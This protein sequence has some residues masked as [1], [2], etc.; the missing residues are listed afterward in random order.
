M[1]VEWTT[2]S[3]EQ[4]QWLAVDALAVAVGLIEQ[5][6]CVKKMCV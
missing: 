1:G 3:V 2:G 6:V 5:L 4:Q